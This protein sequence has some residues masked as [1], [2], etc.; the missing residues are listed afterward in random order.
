MSGTAYNEL[1]SVNVISCCEGGGRRVLCK[2]LATV[3]FFAGVNNL[4]PT[5]REG[6]V[7]TCVCQSFCS[8]EVG[9]FWSQ[10]PSRSPVSCPFGGGG[11]SGT[12][13]LAYLDLL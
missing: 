3:E 13:L 6:N 7:F 10:V 12:G 1:I 2:M 5:A 9:Y 8:G 11:A 4:L